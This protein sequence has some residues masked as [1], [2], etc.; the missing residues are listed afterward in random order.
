MGTAVLSLVLL[1]ALQ[2]P[3]PPPPPP[4]PGA[5]TVPRDGARDTT[6]PKTGTGVIRG[7]VTDQET[8]QPIARASV[9]ITSSVLMQQTQ[10]RGLQVLATSDGL[11]EARNLPAGDYTIT[12]APGEFRATHLRQ[13]FGETRPLDTSRPRRPRPLT[14]GDGEVREDVNIALWRASAVEGRVVDEFGEPMAGME[15]IVRV[16]GSDQRVGMMGPYQFVT[17]DR[18][19]FRAYGIG[20]GRYTICANPRNFGPS[21]T[22]I[23]DRAIQTC[24]PAAVVDADAAPVTVTMGDVAGIEIRIQRSRAFTVSG[25]VTDSSGAPLDRVNMNVIR[26]DRSNAASVGGVEV[27]PGG[28][29][30]ARGL[31]PGDYAMSAEVGSRFQ[32]E[33][34]R[35][36][37]IGYTPF[38]IDNSNIEGLL[39]ATSK[40]TRLSGRVVFE[41]DV[42][43][44]PASTMRINAVPDRSN[45]LFM[46]M[47]PSPTAEVKA[48][49]TFELTG[50]FGP[51]TVLPSP[52]RD[53]TVK[54]IR[55]KGQDITDMAVDFAGSHE[56]DA[57]EIVLTNQGARVSGRVTDDK[58]QPAFDAM[59]VFLP[60]DPARWK[61]PTPFGFGSMPP[62]PDGSYQ[63][64]L[65]RAGEYLI[66]AIS[67]DDVPRGP[68]DPEFLER[69]AKHAQRITLV[70]NERQTIDL[71]LTK[72]HEH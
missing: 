28:Q 65:M 53:W 43:G 57:L 64:P 61:R 39:V 46:T 45:R 49:L 70:E 21:Q 16:A 66:L 68:S 6:P 58:G 11:F 41:E 38:R 31:T 72:L 14:L 59:V 40:P 5:V 1:A 67:M 8:G 20:P 27:R 18:G 2:N 19:F 23:K 4:V 24:H 26:L 51:M 7:K 52:P 56:S 15:V 42:A 44:R 9:T 30:V 37:E 47:G 10:G 12:A 22:E 29:F 33:D 3:P 35:E 34:K 36:R 62:K 25:I 71:R 54:A 13:V 60:A 69:I 48:D 17:D 55:F 63:T 50:L 32:P